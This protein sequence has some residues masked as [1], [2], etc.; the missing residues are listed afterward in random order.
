MELKK[1]HKLKHFIVFKCFSQLILTFSLFLL[2]YDSVIMYCFYLKAQMCRIKAQQYCKDC[3]MLLSCFNLGF[4]D[5][6]VRG[7]FSPLLLPYLKVL[8]LV[9]Q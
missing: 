6:L 1:G 9:I 5:W 8:T 3:R 7:V 2:N 4:S